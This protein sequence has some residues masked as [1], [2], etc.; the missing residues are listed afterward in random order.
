LSIEERRAA[1]QN[2][3]EGSSLGEQSRGSV[4]RNSNL[5]F[6]QILVNKS[7]SFLAE[8]ENESESM[9]NEDDQVE[10]DPVPPITVPPIIASTPSISPESQPL[11][12]ENAM[13]VRTTLLLLHNRIQLHSLL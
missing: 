13:T 11:F 8:D 6:F 2:M 10:E 4:T 7:F 12:E 1:Y 5:C 3:K 9:E